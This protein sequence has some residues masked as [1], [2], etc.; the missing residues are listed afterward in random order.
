MF[1]V[2]AGYY[3]LFISTSALSSPYMFQGEFGTIE[4]AEAFLD[5][6]FDTESDPIFYERKIFPQSR[7]YA[8][9]LTEEEQED[10]LFDVMPNGLILQ[11][12]GELATT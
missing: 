3:E 10:M 2:Y 1:K 7:T 12:F 8:A 9:F 6:N 11:A 4:E 5:E